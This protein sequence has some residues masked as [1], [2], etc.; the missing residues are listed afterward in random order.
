LAEEHWHI[1]SADVDDKGVE[2]DQI[3]IEDIYL[4]DMEL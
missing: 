3:D 4:K 2:I 1:A